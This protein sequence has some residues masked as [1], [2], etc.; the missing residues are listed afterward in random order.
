MRTA[1]ETAD[2]NAR[3]LL[4]EQPR[5]REVSAYGISCGCRSGALEPFHRIWPE[6]GR[7]RP[8]HGG[9]HVLGRLP[10]RRSLRGVFLGFAQ[11]G[12]GEGERDQV[13]YQSPGQ[14]CAVA[15]D[16]TR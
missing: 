11:L 6:H 1:A 15:P 9:V 12:H 7:L 13:R 5:H 3:Q 16:V 10:G 4:A 2:R 14:D 8:G